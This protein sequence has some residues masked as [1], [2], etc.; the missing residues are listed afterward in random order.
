[1]VLKIIKNM[2]FPTKPWHALL[3]FLALAA[4]FLAATRHF[5]PGAH[6]LPT[7][8]LT[9][10][11]AALL[12]PAIHLAARFPGPAAKTKL[13]LVILAVA[14]LYVIW[15]MAYKPASRADLAGRKLPPE[16]SRVFEAEALKI[17]KHNLDCKIEK[18]G[19]PNPKTTCGDFWEPGAGQ[20][21]LLIAETTAG[22]LTDTKKTSL[23]HSLELTALPAIHSLRATGHIIAGSPF[24]TLTVKGAARIRLIVTPNSKNFTPLEITDTAGFTA[25]LAIASQN[26][27]PSLNLASLKVGTPKMGEP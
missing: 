25:I 2:V 1:M 20:P 6:M 23:R 12:I 11:V 10:G 18:R 21:G 3:G 14:N 19:E 24:S 13:L 16:I 7:E 5:L 4:L 8:R 22:L 27:T 17:I 9:A 26:G 15:A